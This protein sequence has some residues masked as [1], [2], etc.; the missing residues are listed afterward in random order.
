MMAK[1]TDFYTQMR[2]IKNKI[3]RE[4]F[5]HATFKALIN[6]MDY[7][8]IIDILYES[9]RAGN[10]FDK[11][12]KGKNDAL[13]MWLRENLK[14]RQRALIG[15]YFGD[16][17]FPNY[18]AYFGNE[19]TGKIYDYLR[20]EKDKEEE[21]KKNTLIPTQI[22]L[23]MWEY[24]LQAR[25]PQNT[26][27]AEDLSYLFQYLEETEEKI[28]NLNL[29]S[30]EADDR[31]SA[32]EEAR[33]EKQD[34]YILGI[35][36]TGLVRALG[37]KETLESISS[38]WAPDG[39]IKMLVYDID[40]FDTGENAFY[41]AWMNEKDYSDDSKNA[42]RKLE[43]LTS[44]NDW[45]GKGKIEVRYYPFFLP[46]DISLSLSGTCVLGLNLP[47]ARLTKRDFHNDIHHSTD[48]V[49][50]PFPIIKITQKRHPRLFKAMRAFVENLW[51]QI[52]ERDTRSAV[53]WADLSKKNRLKAGGNDLDTS[54]TGQEALEKGK[55]LLNINFH[56]ADRST[57]EELDKYFGLELAKKPF[58]EGLSE[59][60][61]LRKD[62]YS[63][64]NGK[65]EDYPKYI[66][67][68]P[69]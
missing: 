2:Q 61:A 29:S 13:K 55:K 33:K 20:E 43:E 57:L 7:D 35:G 19:P 60:Q 49:V 63:F 17:E 51:D 21:D 53:F 42:R 59:W 12:F 4:S 1:K 15:E 11:Y 56:D 48:A 30:I 9:L 47:F 44:S 24:V 38:Q 46:F 5:D 10:I 27:G 22:F 69:V 28:I 26:P 3:D 25:Q 64:I 39:K 18:M 52:G 16:L 50:R 41:D 65:A 45:P 31:W 36:F 34:V 58:Y 37:N 66:N 14:R 32:F 23:R 67:Q 54:E 68:P 40:K 8:I 6:G 62:F